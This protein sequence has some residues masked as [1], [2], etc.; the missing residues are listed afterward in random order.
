LVTWRDYYKR[1]VLMERRKERV[2]RG[3]STGATMV[4]RF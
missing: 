1:E 3:L 2:R 4:V